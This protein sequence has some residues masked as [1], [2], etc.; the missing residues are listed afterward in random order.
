[1]ARCQ[2]AICSRRRGVAIVER[3]DEETTMKTLLLL[4]HAKSSWDDPAAAD[5]DRALAK[6]GLRDAPAVGEFLK[7]ARVPVDLVLSST[8]RRAR[9]T[10]ELVSETA[11]F[12]DLEFTDEIYEASVRQLL[13]VVRGIHD[14]HTA[15]LM[16]GH[17]PGFE[18]LFGELCGPGASFRVPT[19]AVGCIE[20]DVPRWR[21]VDR[22]LGTLLWF[23]APRVIGVHEG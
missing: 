5:F 14:D 17:N 1:M 19:A 2:A 10:A 20:L 7:R 13:D 8:A 18:G 4:R 6:R 12:G 22:G 3:F 11:G 16:V 21:D 23:I 15:V 9:Q